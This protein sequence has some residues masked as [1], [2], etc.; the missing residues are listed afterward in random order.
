MITTAEVTYAT[1]YAD[2]GYTCELAELQNAQIIDT[3]LAS[4]QKTGYRFELRGCEAE[5]PG[6][7]NTKFR[8]V[9][10]PLTQNT[11]GLKAFCS[12]ESAIVKYDKSGSA[13]NC[14]ENGVAI[15]SE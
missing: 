13:D 12:D 10:Y 9:A 7:P 3:A 5:T 4:G 6:G 15:G 8:V 2:K 11:T 1:T 14:V